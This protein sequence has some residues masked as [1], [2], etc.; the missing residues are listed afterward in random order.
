MQG[1]TLLDGRRSRSPGD[2]QCIEH[3]EMRSIFRQPVLHQHQITIALL[4]GT[5]ARYESGFL[6]PFPG[7]PRSL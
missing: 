7:D 1:G 4:A 5:G 3:Q 2:P 6:Q